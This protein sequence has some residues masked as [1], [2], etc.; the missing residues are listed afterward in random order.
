MQKNPEDAN[1]SVGDLRGMITS[2]VDPGAYIIQKKMQRFAA[3][4]TGSAAYMH[5]RKKELTT[6]M[7]QEGPATFW[8][9]LT[10]PNWMWKDLQQLF[11]D[12]PTQEEGEDTI[13]YEKRCEK[14]A[15]KKYF[16]SP[17]IVN[18]FFIKRCERFVGFLFG[19]DCFDSLWTWYRFEWQRRGNIHVHGMARTKCDPGFT[20]LSKKVIDG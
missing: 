2:H 6:L 14:E 16:E 10:M 19:P 18:E 20:D 15:R 11:G 4:I 3:N 12:V 13:S 17:H 1:L 5:T 7:D 8:F 9:T